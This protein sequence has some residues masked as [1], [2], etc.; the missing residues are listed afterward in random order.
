MS[1]NCGFYNAELLS[2]EGLLFGLLLLL[3]RKK[4]FFLF[5]SNN[6][7]NNNPPCERSV[8][9]EN[10]DF[11]IYSWAHRFLSLYKL[12]FPHPRGKL[13]FLQFRLCMFCGILCSQNSVGQAS[14]ILFRQIQ[15]KYGSALAPMFGSWRSCSACPCNVAASWKLKVIM[16]HTPNIEEG[17]GGARILSE[18]QSLSE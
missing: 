11:L 18:C 4:S 13:M 3:K 14:S 9:C 10:C 2:D 17:G 6:N 15:Q 16:F 7:P 8:L 12:V 5:R 1:Q